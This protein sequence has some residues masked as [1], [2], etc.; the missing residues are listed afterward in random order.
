MVQQAFDSMYDDIEQNYT[1]ELANEFGR[2][3]SPHARTLGFYMEV[4]SGLIREGEVVTL[5]A[6]VVDQDN[7]LSRTS[8]QFTAAADDIRPEVITDFRR[9]AA[10]DVEPRIRLARFNDQKLARRPRG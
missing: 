7:A 9:R 5:T 2:R 4:P 8:I 6:Q 3:D 10:I 1:V